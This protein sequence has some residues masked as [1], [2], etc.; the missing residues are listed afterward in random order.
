MLDYRS[1]TF[2][3]YC[4]Y[5]SWR[6]KSCLF[7]LLWGD[8]YFGKHPYKWHTSFFSAV[9]RLR[10]AP[11]LASV[12][13]ANA[14]AKPGGGSVGWRSGGVR[15]PTYQRTFYGKSLYIWLFPKMVV[16]QN[17]WF[18]MEN[19]IKMDD[20]GVPLFSE[21]PIYISPIIVGIVWLIPFISYCCWFRNPKEPLGRPWT[22]VRTN[23]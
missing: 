11:W 3:R 10:R 1:V 7:Q 23:G 14:Q 20:L 22:E 9:F 2:N 15:A 16:P 17:G 8:P 12:A 4:Q 13:H 19:P 5:D 21:A 18:I 6:V